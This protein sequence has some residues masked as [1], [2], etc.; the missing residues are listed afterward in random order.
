MWLFF[1]KIHRER[2][3]ALTACHESIAR[4]PSQAVFARV[5]VRSCSD[6]DSDPCVLYVADFSRS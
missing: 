5:V 1:K 3:E 2:A 6:F 4:H